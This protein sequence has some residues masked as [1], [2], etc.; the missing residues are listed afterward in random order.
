MAQYPNPYEYLDR[1]LN[2]IETVLTEVSSLIKLNTQTEALQPLLSRKEAA[3]H[4]DTS[5]PTLRALTASGQIPE[6]KIGRS[7]KYK[8]EDL[9]QFIENQK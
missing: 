6:I 7:V 8:L 3:D 9:D 4:L 1:R 5:L 2:S